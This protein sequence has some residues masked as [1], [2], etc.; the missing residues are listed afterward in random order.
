MANPTP[1]TSAPDWVARWPEAYAIVTGFYPESKPKGGAPQCRPL[2]VTQVLRGR[3]TGKIA[4]RIA[5]GTSI[6]R[7]PERAGIDLI[8]QN[9]SDLDAC[10]LQ[11]PTRFVIAPKDQ[12]VRQWT[13]EFF[14]PWGGCSTPRRGKLPPDLQHEYAW[15]MARYLPQS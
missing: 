1:T 13:P 10:G 8:I 14:R 5:Y 11:S 4:L 15:L 12:I 7:F 6:T 2:L 9:I 3:T